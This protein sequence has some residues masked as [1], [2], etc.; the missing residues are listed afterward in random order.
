[1]SYLWYLAAVLCGVMQSATAK[2]YHRRGGDAAVFNIGKSAFAFALFTCM[3]VATGFSVPM[4]SA[5]YGLA[6]GV[7]LA[8]S[9]YCGYMALCYGPMALTGLIVSF[10]VVM[11][12]LYGIIFCKEGGSYFRICG[13]LC[14]VA[15]MVFVNLPDK[16][17]HTRKQ[18]MENGKENGAAT[19]TFA[20]K[21][22]FG[23]DD[24]SHAAQKM[25]QKRGYW[26]T[27]VA[28]TFLCNGICAI[29]QKAHGMRF[30]GDYCEEFMFFAMAVCTVVFGIQTLYVWLG[31]RK[32]GKSA[33][34]PV[35][36]PSVCKGVFWLAAL[37][38]ICNAAANYATTRLSGTENAS[39]LFPAVSVGTV[40]VSLLC[41]WLLFAE[42]PRWNHVPAFVLGLCAIILLRM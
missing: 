23:N 30:S 33:A 39:V 11:P 16:K 32:T 7:A 36:K 35:P 20:S 10:S 18:G 2:G 19:V 17:P 31:R 37:S 21:A 25:P 15:A 4:A 26:L 12:V 14:F 1:M 22:S 38:G 40:C 9:M 41:G 42:K 28:A 13:L 29:L 34:F 3:A 6:Y 27:F 8:V 5:G 24:A